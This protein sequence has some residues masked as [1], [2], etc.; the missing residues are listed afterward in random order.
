MSPE[1][2]KNALAAKSIVF[3]SWK[4]GLVSFLAEETS[5]EDAA[6][7]MQDVESSVADALRRAPGIFE[8]EDVSPRDLTWLFEHASLD[9]AASLIAIDPPYIGVKESGNFVFTD[10]SI[11]ASGSHG[12]NTTNVAGILLFSNGASATYLR[13]Y[14]TGAISDITAEIIAQTFANSFGRTFAGAVTAISGL[15]GLRINWNA[16]NADPADW[17]GAGSGNTLLVSNQLQ[18]DRIVALRPIGFDVLGVACRNNLWLG[19]PTGDADE[20]AD[21]RLRFPGIGC[22]SERTACVT[23]KGVI[24]LSD[25]G[26]IQFD[27]NEVKV[28]SEPIN[29]LL[30]PL[31][32]VEMS[33][34][35]AIYNAPQQRYQLYTPEGVWIYELP[36]EYHPG[37][38]YYRAYIG[39]SAAMFTDQEG[40]YF[41]NTIPGTWLDW[42][43][44]WNEMSVS[45]QNAAAVVY[46]GQ[47]SLLGAEQYNHDSYFDQAQDTFWQTKQSAP[48][49][50]DLQTTESFEIEYRSVAETTI[51]I[52]LL[53]ADGEATGEV[54]ITLPSTSGR[55]ISRMFWAIVTGHGTAIRVILE[56]GSPEIYSIRP[57]FPQEAPAVTA[58]E[59]S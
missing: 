33:S 55:R 10:E 36:Q 42:N 25:H 49:A 16:S 32:Y 51:Q 23:P 13:D 1:A 38:W 2:L 9:Y 48:Q 41:W 8:V 21:F 26:V 5:P 30:L 45:Q 46:N 15:E 58:L 18:A 28:I 56:S 50:T 14:A 34:Y 17:S 19:Y 43:L 59:T 27:I 29:N 11:A 24:C 44:T 40:G 12:W 47:G 4:R 37:R 35:Y 54:T 39:D 6:V 52:A 7:D 22:T 57:V 20:P 31:N 53:D 3:N